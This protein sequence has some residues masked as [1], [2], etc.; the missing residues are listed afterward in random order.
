MALTPILSGRIL[1]ALALKLQGIDDTKIMK[2]GW[3]TS[4][5]FLQYI[6]NQIAHLTKDIS[7]KMSIDL[8][9]VNVA[10]IEPARA[11][12]DQATQHN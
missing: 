11:D 7:R 8:P 6:H 4:L 3:W 9:F 10:V 1:F 5:T 12:T 2:I